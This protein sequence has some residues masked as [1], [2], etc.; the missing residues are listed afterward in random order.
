[1]KVSLSWLGVILIF[2]VILYFSWYGITIYETFVNEEN[3]KN[4]KIESFVTKELYSGIEIS[5]CPAQSDTSLFID[6]KGYSLCCQGKSTSD[7][8]YGN[9][10]CSLSESVRNIPTCS[11]WVEAYYKERGIGRCPASMPNYFEN[12]KKFGCT[13]GPLNK[14]ATGPA[15]PTSSK[16]CHIYAAKQDDEGKLDSCTNIKLLDSTVCF[17]T[18]TITSEKQ[19]VS[20]A[21]ETLPALISCK[22]GDITEGTAGICQDDDS[23]VR[24]MK[25]QVNDDSSK[26]SSWKAGCVSWDPIQKLNFCSVIERFKIL[27]SQ[28]FTDLATFNIFPSA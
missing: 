19:L 4:R 20:V 26:L 23:I 16:T 9:V 18:N 24:N 25:A 6:K 1:M 13:S 12:G 17:K 3:E 14:D 15:D 28:P 2:S 21:N 7:T 11:E 10:L 27:K 22:Y 5:T 8:C